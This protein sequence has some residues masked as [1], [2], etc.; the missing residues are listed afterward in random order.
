MTKKDEPTKTQKAIELIDKNKVFLDQFGE[1]QI[2]LTRGQHTEVHPL[3]SSTTKAHII[4]EFYE[5]YLQTISKN[6][7]AEIILFLEGYAHKNPQLTLHNRATWHNKKLYYDLTNKEWEKIEINKEGWKIIQ[8]TE[9]KVITDPLFKR[10]SHQ[11]PQETPSK[12]EKPLSKIINIFNIPE[13]NK[14][15]LEILIISYFLPDIPR[16]ILVLHG[17]QGSAKTTLMLTI[18]ELV[19]P[20][21]IEVVSMP[22]DEEGLALQLNTHYFLPYDNIGYINEEKSNILCRAITGQGF[23]KRKLYTDDE[24]KMFK[25][26]RAISLNG[27]NAIPGKPDLLDRSVIIGVERIEQTSRRTEEEVIKEVKSLKPSVLGYIFTTLSKAMVIK[28]NIKPPNL[29]RMAD[30]A[31]WGEC[32]SQAMGYKEGLFLEKYSEN[33]S[34]QHSEILDAHPVGITLLEYLTK[35]E[36]FPH[37]I[38]PSYLFTELSSIAQNLGIKSKL[39]PQ[40]PHILIRRL[41]ELKINLKESGWGFEMKRTGT[42]RNLVFFSNSSEITEKK[43]SEKNKELRNSQPRQFLKLPIKR[44]KRN[45]NDASDAN[46]A[47]Y[48]PKELNE[49]KKGRGGRGTENTVSTVTSVTKQQGKVASLASQSDDGFENRTKLLEFLRDNDQL[50]ISEFVGNTV[51]AL[52]LLKQLVLEKKAREIKKGVFVYE[53]GF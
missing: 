46:D 11:K 27:I 42:K 12:E 1:P 33:I 6:T 21:I 9:N 25:Y 34:K 4:T 41:N 19:D 29:Q 18:R 5:Y 53:R 47:T 43:E 15:L 35:I 16:P 39:F 31:L 17:V 52:S 3:K 51:K 26:K 23:D 20:S 38:T 40:A 28:E 13:Q 14:L 37:Q 45:L 48:V 22:K 24:M 30:F 50:D 44:K 7:L 49:K 8:S 32:I 2:F 36:E 10:L